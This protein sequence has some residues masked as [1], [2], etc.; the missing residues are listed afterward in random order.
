MIR[1]GVRAAAAAIGALGVGAVIVAAAPASAS[2]AGQTISFTEHQISDH[3]FNLGSGHGIAV[4]AIELSANKLMQGR[5]QIGHDGTSCTVTRLSG[6]TAAD[7][8]I[9][10]EVLAHGQIDSQSAAS[11]SP[12]I[13]AG[14][15]AP[16]M[17]GLTRCTAAT[18]T[19][20]W[21]LQSHADGCHL[22]DPAACAAAGKSLVLPGQ[23]HFA[24]ISGSSRSR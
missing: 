2:P 21:I 17:A 12:E 8:C 6:G 13:C 15:A 18:G 19:Y 22:T 23:V 16:G 11:P 14:L 3:N 5:T 10:V 20:K 9:A 4:G 24:L 1:I 7:L